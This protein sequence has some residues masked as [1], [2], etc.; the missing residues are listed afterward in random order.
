MAM[1]FFPKTVDGYLYYEFFGR[2]GPGFRQRV[3]YKWLNRLN[4]LLHFI[5]WGLLLT[6]SYV[7]SKENR[8]ELSL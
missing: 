1:V 7:T 2:Q 5:Q 4:C 8:C 3:V 6:V